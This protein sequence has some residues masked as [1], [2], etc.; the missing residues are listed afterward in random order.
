MLILQSLRWGAL[1]GYAITQAIRNGSDDV[2]QVETGSLYPALHRLEKKGWLRSSWG[3]TEN[4]QR[5]RFYQLTRVG[6]KQ[7]TAEHTKWSLMAAAIEALMKG[8]PV[9]EES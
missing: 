7:L 8:K 9:G 2:L 5:A 6:K 1:H 4:N 3:T